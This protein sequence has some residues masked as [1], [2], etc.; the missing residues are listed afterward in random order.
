[1]PTHRTF[2]STFKAQVVLEVLSGS[3]TQPD[4]SQGRA[5]ARASAQAG[6]DHALEASFSGER[7]HSL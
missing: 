7:S 4:Q 2:S 1:M 5:S 6:L 3:K